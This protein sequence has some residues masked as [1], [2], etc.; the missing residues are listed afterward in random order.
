MCQKFAILGPGKAGSAL[1]AALS[2][3]GYEVRSAKRGQSSQPP[4]GPM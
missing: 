2:R 1:Q 3:A 4:P